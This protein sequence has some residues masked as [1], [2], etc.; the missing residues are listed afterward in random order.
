[1][2]TQTRLKE[3]LEYN[4]ETGDFFWKVSRGGKTIGEK[5]GTL[6]N[7]G[8]I[9]LRLDMVYYYAHQLARLYVHGEFPTEIDHI[10]RNRANNIFNNLRITTRSQNRANST[11]SIR[12]YNLPRGIEF[13]PGGKTYRPYIRVNKKLIHLGSFYSL[14]DAVEIRKKAIIT[15]FGEF[16]SSDELTELSF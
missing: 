14:E 15:H 4:S 10:D 6:H 8:Y 3:L 1:M 9:R 7:K 11:N 5:A 16:S 13:G 12:N 2:V